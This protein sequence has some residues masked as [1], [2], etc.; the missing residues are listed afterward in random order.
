M[1]ITVRCGDVAVYLCCNKLQG[2]YRKPMN[3]FVAVSSGTWRQVARAILSLWLQETPWFGT[4]SKVGKVGERSWKPAGKGQE[5]HPLWV[6]RSWLSPIWFR[7]RH[8]PYVYKS[9]SLVLSWWMKCTYY[10]LLFK[11][12][13]NIIFPSMARYPNSEI[14]WYGNCITLFAFC[15]LY[16]FL[17]VVHLLLCQT[18]I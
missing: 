6:F 11:I 18:F 3:Q 4:R 14:D 8:F 17:F 5:P 12:P 16:S 13:F 2:L 15:C 1:H 10:V 7:C 9:L